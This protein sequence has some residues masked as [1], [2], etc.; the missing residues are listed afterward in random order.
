MVLKWALRTTTLGLTVPNPP[1]DS[2]A[3]VGISRSVNLMPL[4]RSCLDLVEAYS[5]TTRAML[6][7]SRKTQPLPH[8]ASTIPTLIKCVSEPVHRFEGRERRC[9][10]CTIWF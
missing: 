7:R 2:Q 9:G 6:S 8:E 10:Q 4:C 3:R 1:L 5:R